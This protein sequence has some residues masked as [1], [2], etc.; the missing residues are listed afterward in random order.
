MRSMGYVVL[1][2]GILFAILFGLAELGGAHLGITPIYVTVILIVIGA[3]LAKSG[4]GIVQSEAGRAAQHASAQTAPAPGQP[5][6]PAGQFSTVELPMT[7]QVAAIIASQSA[8]SKRILLYIVAALLLLFV[9]LGV[10]LAA[11]DKTPRRRPHLPDDLRWNGSGKRSLNL[12]TLL[13]DNAETSSPRSK[14]RAP[15]SGQQ[16]R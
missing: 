8:R 6:V 4:K 12:R 15:T 16:A 14:R 3:G 13:A 11:T 10:V 7:P 1:V 2:I 9:G 5:A